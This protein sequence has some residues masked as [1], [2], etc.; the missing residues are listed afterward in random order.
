MTQ[1]KPTSAAKPVAKAEPV[2]KTETPVLQKLVSIG[3]T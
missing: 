1:T 2:N 3:I